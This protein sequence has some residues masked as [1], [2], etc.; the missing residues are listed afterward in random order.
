M[1]QSLQPSAN[2]SR[3]LSLVGSP[4]G[5][6][7]SGFFKE[8]LASCGTFRQCDWVNKLCVA[9]RSLHSIART[10]Y[11]PL[12]TTW[13]RSRGA[14]S[15]HLFVAK[16]AAGA[17]QLWENTQLLCRET[18]LLISTTRNNEVERG[19]GTVVGQTGGG[20]S[21]WQFSPWMLVA[22]LTPQAAL[23]GWAQAA[24]IFHFRQLQVGELPTIFLWSL[25]QLLWVFCIGY[26]G[27]AE[28]GGSSSLCL[29]GHHMSGFIHQHQLGFFPL[30]HIK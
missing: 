15:C 8:I 6:R 24:P 9:E 4:Q 27:G 21:T 19:T 10:I 12:I 18:S 23:T 2:L 26:L 25:Q 28:S 22:S 29:P 13:Q 11:S 17:E 20:V 7:I 14:E 16:Q 30:E 3:D 5:S 1:A